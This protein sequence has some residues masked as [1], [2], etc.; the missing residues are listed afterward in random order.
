MAHRQR[1]N[2]KLARRQLY[3]LVRS[4]GARTHLRLEQTAALN[5]ENNEDD[6][7]D[8]RNGRVRDRVDYSTRPVSEL[9]PHRRQ[10][11]E[12]LWCLQPDIRRVN[13]EADR[14]ASDSNGNPIHT[15]CSL[16]LTRHNISGGEPSVDGA[17]HT[18][19]KADTEA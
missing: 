3:R 16:N 12:L 5:A 2:G 13:P 8:D 1:V 18:L 4:I 17:Q 14:Q 11:G 6:A 19:S 9:L 15:W 10:L 7:G